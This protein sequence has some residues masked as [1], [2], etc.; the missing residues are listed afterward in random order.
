MSE[1]RFSAAST[2]VI[3]A[4]HVSKQDGC[5]PIHH[6][7]SKRFHGWQLF[8]KHASPSSH[9]QRNLNAQHSNC[10]SSQH[11]I[12]ERTK[13]NWTN[14]FF[15]QLTSERGWSKATHFSRSWWCS[16]ETQAYP[17]NQVPP[18]HRISNAHV[19]L[20]WL[21]GSW[22]VRHRTHCGAIATSDPDKTRRDS[23]GDC[24]EQVCNPKS[25]ATK[26]EDKAALLAV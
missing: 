10:D 1:H 3:Q 9:E 20:R 21:R 16:I 8:G 11:Q 24:G 23:F 5:L 15:V 17:W 13:V 18:A 4:S 2:R 6:P 22:R 12:H 26:D 14:R 25:E 7:Y 19:R